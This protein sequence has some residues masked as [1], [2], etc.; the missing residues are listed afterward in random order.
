MSQAT[1]YLID[2]E[3]VHESGLYGSEE[4]KKHEYIHLFFTQNADKINLEFIASIPSTNLHYHEIPT[5]NQSLDR[6]LITF[7]GYLIGQNKNNTGNHKYIIV[8][9][10]SGYDSIVSFWQKESYN[11][12]RQPAISNANVKEQPKSTKTTKLTNTPTSKTKCTLNNKLQQALSDDGYKEPYIG[13]ISSIVLKHFGKEKFTNNVHNS[14]RDNFYDYAKIYQLIKPILS[15]FASSPKA[16]KSKETTTTSLNKE[17]QQILS[18]ANF[19]NEI[20]SYVASLVAKHHNEKN[21][22]QTIYRLIISKYGQKKGLN[23]YNH[24]KKHI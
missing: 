13:E 2:F 9:K 24:I 8:S 15:Q 23:I 11:V 19:P 1:Y 17:I 6:H 5:G 3:N 18:N 21:S 22:K 16:T 10:D 12:L 7:L 14:L 20:I 4:L